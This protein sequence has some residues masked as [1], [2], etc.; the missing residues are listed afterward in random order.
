MGAAV[1]AVGVP[2]FASAATWTSRAT[3][4]GLLRAG[5][6]ADPSVPGRAYLVSFGG[7]AVVWMTE[8]RG[9][10]WVRHFAPESVGSFSVFAGPPDLLVAITLDR[11]VWRSVDQARTWHQVGC[12]AYA[13]DP[14]DP[15]RL[16]GIDSPTG[17]LQRSPDGGA[18]WQPATTV[19]GPLAGFTYTFD[20]GGRLWALSGTGA[21]FRSTDLGTT[22]AVVSG[23]PD[24]ILTPVASDATRLWVGPWRSLDGGGSWQRSGPPDAACDGVP[25]PGPGSPPAVWTLNCNGLHRST[26]GGDLWTLMAGTA[27]HV[28]TPG[29][30]SVGVLA[31][32]R[33]AIVGGWQGP[34]LVEDGHPPQYRGDGLPSLV[35]GPQLADPSVPGRAYSSTF[36]TTNGGATWAPLPGAPPLGLARVGQRLVAATQDALVSRPAAGGTATTLR[37]GRATVASDPGGRRLFVVSGDRVS[38]STDGRTLR[39]L[40]TRVLDG[41]ET[42][43]VA[44]AAGGRL[45]RTVAL[46]YTHGRTRLAVSQD[47]GR[48][49]FS[50]PLGPGVGK[51]L[52]DAV[53]GRLIL[54]LDPAGNLTISRH[55]GRQFGSHRPFVS[56]VAVD[57]SRRGRWYIVQRGKLLRTVDA[58]RTWQPMA[59][60]SRRGAVGALTAGRGRLWTAAIDRISWLPLAVAR[61]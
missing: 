2:S 24:G 53:D 11:T 10:H 5:V 32:G 59:G 41:S 9:A 28:W 55:G 60:P 3:P 48:S 13:V 36:M 31:G 1:V 23:V 34:W 29:V 38:T 26:D 30:T 57:P 61:P 52:V 42:G 33:A 39:L 27:E 25:S 45:G 40:P 18:S 8:D 7:S 21:V 46:E 47:G 12:C 35:T 4:H 17:K 37:A 58:G 50:R 19:A 56:S 15:Q 14:N 6:V 22:W 54:V 49:F 16:I 20:G 44:V 43:V 51:V